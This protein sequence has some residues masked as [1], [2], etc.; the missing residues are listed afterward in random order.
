MKKLNFDSNY[1]FINTTSKTDQNCDKN[2]LER[3]SGLKWTC[4]G[5]GV[6]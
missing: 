4:T 2:Y 1:H 5:E 6:S 3:Q